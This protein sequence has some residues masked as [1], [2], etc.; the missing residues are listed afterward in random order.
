MEFSVANQ[1]K[2]RWKGD[3]GGGDDRIPR[4]IRNDLDAQL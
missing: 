2:R 4:R 3:A 1:N